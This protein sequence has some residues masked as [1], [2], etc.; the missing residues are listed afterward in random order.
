[1]IGNHWPSRG[2]GQYESEP[3]RII[4]GETLSCFHQRILEE[5]NKEEKA[6][7]SSYLSFIILEISLAIK[8]S[9]TSTRP[10]DYERYVK[11]LTNC[12]RDNQDNIFKDLVIIVI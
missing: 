1:L 8:P 6:C 2:G 7:L 10:L 9:F 3:Y 5:N 4:A 11:I 12:G